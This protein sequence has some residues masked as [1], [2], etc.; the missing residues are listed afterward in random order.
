MPGFFKKAMFERKTA[1][2]KLDVLYCIIEY[3]LIFQLEIN[4]S[5]YN[6]IILYYMNNNEYVNSRYKE[7]KNIMQN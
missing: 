3:V 6:I 7:I 4:I 2:L 1:L 5:L